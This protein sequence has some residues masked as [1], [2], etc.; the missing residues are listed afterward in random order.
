MHGRRTILVLRPEQLALARHTARRA[1]LVIAQVA[2]PLPGHAQQLAVELD[3]QPVTDLR[4]ALTTTDAKLALLLAPDAFGDEAPDAALLTQPVA[5][6]TTIVSTSPI[7]ASAL[8]LTGSRYLDR[9]RPGLGGH[10]ADA[11]LVAPLLAHAEAIAS[12]RDAL[13]TFGPADS[14]TI[15]LSVPP[16]LDLLGVRVLGALDLLH[17]I[18]GEPERIDAVHAHRGTPTRPPPPGDALRGV[19]GTISAHLRYAAGASASLL[20]SD[21]VD[22]WS[23]RIDV[24][25]AAGSMTITDIAMT[26]HDPQGAVVDQWTSP[27]QEERT[28]HDQAASELAG[29]ITDVLDGPAR[30]PRDHAAVLAAAQAL[31]LSAR[32]AHAE[33]PSAIR[34]LAGLPS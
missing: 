25:G 30:P 4:A 19:A 2:S 21:R 31:L 1:G 33:S 12:T 24:V 34:R 8:E 17:S 13:A 11:I 18:F 28:S 6:G 16:A 20:A 26:W 5:R 23:L 22:A 32:T 9:A 29:A 3:A 27:T 7:P 14:V 15:R 10:P